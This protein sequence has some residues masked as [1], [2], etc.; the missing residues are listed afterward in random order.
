[1]FRIISGILA[2]TGLVIWGVH[3]EWLSSWTLSDKIA[4]IAS[5]AG[6]LQFIALI[7]TIWI[8]K[9][10]AERQLRAYCLIARAEILN[11]EVGKRPKAK[12]TIK[13]SGQTPAKNFWQVATMAY[14][15]YPITRLSDPDFK[16][17]NKVAHPVPPG[18][19]LDIYPELGA[20]ISEQ[21][22]I[23][24]LKSGA[25]AIYAVGEIG[26]EDA[27]GKKRRTKYKIFCGGPIGFSTNGMSA[28]ED[29]NDYT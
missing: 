25:A 12:I 23:D 22:H 26:Y 24:A 2:I 14:D 21:A 11:V 6:L 7:C 15:T 10:A 13:N 9:G 4:A 8:T 5:I 29:G 18:G 17:T 1:M 3:A 19:Y 27:F 16:K 20:V 28:Y